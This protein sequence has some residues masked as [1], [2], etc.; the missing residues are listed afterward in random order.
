MPIAAKTSLAKFAE[1]EEVAFLFLKEVLE[2]AFKA[3][4]LRAVLQMSEEVAE[5]AK[6]VAGASEDEGQPMSKQ[7]AAVAKA[8]T[9]DWTPAKLKFLA[10][11]K[12]RGGLKALIG[13]ED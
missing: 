9:T 4:G 8:V 3:D 2:E 12:K 10:E 5:H 6:E 1:D 11:V 13:K 7:R